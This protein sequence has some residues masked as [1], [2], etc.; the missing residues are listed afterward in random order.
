M[1]KRPYSPWP[2]HRVQFITICTHEKQ[3]ILGKIY[4]RKDEHIWQP[5]PWGLAASDG[6][7][8]LKLS[9]QLVMIQEYVVMPNHVHM[10]VL[11]KR[12]ND[13]LVKWFISHCKHI[14]AQHMLKVHYT[15]E[16]LW[17]KSFSGHYVQREYTQYALS[18]DMRE[19]QSR[20]HYDSLNTPPP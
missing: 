3:H 18:Q 9:S 14:M 15:S 7:K 5:S 20:W 12:C 13:R 17:E 8:K 19:H 10:L 1:V 2:A 16:P 11:Y 4:K 6:L